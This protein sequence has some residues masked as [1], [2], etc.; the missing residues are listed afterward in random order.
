MEITLKT[1]RWLA[2]VAVALG[3]LLSLAGSGGG[4]GGSDP[5]AGTAPSVTTQ[6]QSQTVSAGAGVSFSV[7]ATGTAP[8]AYQW[9]RDGTAIAGATSATLAFV[10]AAGDSGASFRVVVS[11][12]AGSV[13][14]NAAVLTVG[15][16]GVGTLNGIGVS[17]ADASVWMPVTASVPG[18]PA[19]T[20]TALQSFNLQSVPA[21]E[22]VI[23]RTAAPGH[24]DQVKVAAVR[25]GAVSFV[26]ATLWAAAAAT[27][28][29]PAAGGT[30]AVAG[31]AAQLVLP[32]GALRRTD[33]G[34]LP[35]G[36][37]AVVATALAGARDPDR[38]PGD[39]QWADG[40]VNRFFESLGAIAVSATDATG[41]PLQL[42][43]GQ[44]MALRIPVSSRDTAALPAS[45][46]VYAFDD[47]SARWS[48][49]GTGTLG[50][51]GNGR[52]YEVGVSTLGTFTAGRP[53]DTVQVIGCTQAATNRTR[54]RVVRTEGVAAGFA[55][56]AFSGAD[57]SFSVPIPRNA[58]AVLYTFGSVESS[59]PVVVGPSAADI[60]LAGCQAE[61]GTDTAAPSFVVQP[62]SQAVAA[63][64]IVR[65]SAVLDGRLPMG[66]QW[67]RNGVPIAGETGNTLVFAAA[68]DDDGAVF[69][70]RATNATGSTTSADAVLGVGGG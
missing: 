41:A 31:S 50:G 8:L 59:L 10:A 56:Y 4:S 52:Y 35:S 9:Q 61:R 26:R 20:S 57:G 66:L 18:R 1:G 25:A 24:V 2:G 67:R 15:S 14:S 11:N 16:T 62:Q 33:N 51:S 21:S 47:G 19:A 3:G 63:G 45:T 27:A 54:N 55:G 34:A 40:G 37:A 46:P 29:D 44:T 58:A 39:F 49:A 22:R 70:L 38:L 23:L 65:L 12:A 53:I 28:L 7:V 64:G 36:A 32:A 5:P 13:T 42:A 60:T 43:A 17:S 6:P 68:A 69:T 48:A 30:V